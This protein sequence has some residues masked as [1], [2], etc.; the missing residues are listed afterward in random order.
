M[1]NNELYKALA[2]QR[3]I[4]AIRNFCTFITSIMISL[5]CAW[6]HVQD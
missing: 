6:V 4:R 5:V 1:M 2:E 3:R